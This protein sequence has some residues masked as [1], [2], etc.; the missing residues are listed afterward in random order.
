DTGSTMFALPTRYIQQLGLVKRRE[1]SVVTTAGLKVAAIYDAV[2]LTIM[3]RDCLVEVIEVPDI[4]PALVGQ[5]PLEILDLVVN[6][7]ARTLTGN[8]AHGGEHVLELL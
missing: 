8:P 1:R 5:I 2:R 6:P 4:T 7:M 3:N